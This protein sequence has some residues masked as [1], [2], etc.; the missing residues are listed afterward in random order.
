MFS[1]QDSLEFGIVVD[2]EQLDDPW[3]ILDALRAALD[4]LRELANLHASHAPV[5]SIRPTRSTRRK[6][7]ASSL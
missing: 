6:A 1:Y 7:T 2:R 5:V 4:E 3:P